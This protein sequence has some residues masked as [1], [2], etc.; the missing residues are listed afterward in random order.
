MIVK[1]KDMDFS[2]KNIIVIISGT[3]G[4]GKTTLAL[5]APDVLLIDADNGMCRVNPAHRKDAS[6]CKTFDEL[7]EDI[8]AAKGIYKTI[9]IDTGGAL[10]EMLKQYVIDHPDE[11]KGGT[12]RTGGISLQGFGM[13]KQLFN[14]FSNELKRDFNVVYLFHEQ[15][16]KDDET[17]TYE[18]ICEG[19][20]KT[21]VYQPADL[22]AHM[23]IQDK[24]RVLG[25]TPTEQYFA[26]SAYGIKDLITIPELKDG[27]ENNFLAALFDT[28]RENLKKETANL[29]D[30]Q[31]RYEDIMSGAK[32]M[33]DAVNTPEDIPQCAEAIK[34]LQHALTSEKELKNMLKNRIAELGIKW[35]KNAK[36]YVYADKQ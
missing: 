19:S 13:V 11:F 35:D 5:S 21:A 16:S 36:A 25:F 33:M 26:K 2:G 9:A 1:P 24:K 20:A 15:K 18:I 10:V 29:A 27:D 8:K 12:K 32:S 23:F 17:T 22:A 4:V 28:V 14:D 31:K 3:P 7:R 30:E 34:S 6:I